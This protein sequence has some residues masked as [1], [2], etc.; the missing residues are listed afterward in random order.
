MEMQ[1]KKYSVKICKKSKKVTHLA[2]LNGRLDK[3]CNVD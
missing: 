3:V 1:Y 2:I